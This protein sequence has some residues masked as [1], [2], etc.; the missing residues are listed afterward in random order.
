MASKGSPWIA[1]VVNLSTK[2]NGIEMQRKP[3]VA[4][5]KTQASSKTRATFGHLSLMNLA[6]KRGAKANTIA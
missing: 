1:Q 5:E 6:T 4:A 2:G 3:A